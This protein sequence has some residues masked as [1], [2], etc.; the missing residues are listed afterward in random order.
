MKKGIH[1]NYHEVT[2]T[3]VSCGTTFKTGST[4]GDIRV[5]TCSNCHSFYTDQQRFAKVDGPVD[6]FNQK[7]EIARRAQEAK[8]AK[9]AKKTEK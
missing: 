9:E 6:R 4:R 2:V 5:D 8:K 1:P 3:C 7:L